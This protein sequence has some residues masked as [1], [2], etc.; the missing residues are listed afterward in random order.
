MAADPGEPIQFQVTD[1]GQLL[2]GG[3]AVLLPY[4]VKDAVEIAGTVVVLYDPDVG[5][6]TWGTF[7]NLAAFDRD[8]RPVWVAKTPTSGTG[9]C[10]LSIDSAE[11]LVVRSWSTYICSI[12]AADGSIINKVFTK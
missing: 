2:I 8:G 9:D 5:H 11:P 1:A 3:S 6:R 7:P 4:P 10:Y 12:N